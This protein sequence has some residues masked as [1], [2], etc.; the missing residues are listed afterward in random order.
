ML[1]S[2]KTVYFLPVLLWS[3][4]I[5]YLST[6]SQLPSIPLDFLSPDKLGHLL[7]YAIE[8]LLWIGAFAKSQSWKREHLFWVFLSLALAA[9][10]GT[11][12]EYVQAGIPER[13]FD[14]ADML[15]N[16]IGILLAWLLYQKNKGFFIA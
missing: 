10:Y 1:N 9:S 4:L 3:V 8:T 11:L 16:F 6:S 2:Y 15:A 12:L 13:T 14:Y 5:G 7:F